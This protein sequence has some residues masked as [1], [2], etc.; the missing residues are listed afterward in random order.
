MHVQDPEKTKD[1]VEFVQKLLDERDK[2]EKIIVNSFNDDKTFRNSL[3]QVCVC[4]CA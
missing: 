2:Y 4:V 3:N 1:P